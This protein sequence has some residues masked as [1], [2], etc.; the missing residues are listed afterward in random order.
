MAA[1]TATGCTANGPQG[2]L[3]Q[4]LGIQML[5]GAAFFAQQHVNIEK[6]VP[7]VLTAEH[8]KLALVAKTGRDMRLARQHVVEMFRQPTQTM[9]SMLTVSLKV[10]AVLGSMRWGGSCC[11]STSRSSPTPT[12]PWSSGRRA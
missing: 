9:L 2:V 11:T 3:A 12:R 5:R 7:K 4:F 1:R 6:F 8:V 10:S